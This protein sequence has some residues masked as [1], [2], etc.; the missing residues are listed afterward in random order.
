LQE[1]SQQAG[2]SEAMADLPDPDDDVVGLES[3]AFRGGMLA[4]LADILDAQGQVR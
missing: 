1:L 3:S 4:I 2:F